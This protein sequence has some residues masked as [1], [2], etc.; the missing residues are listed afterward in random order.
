M[1]RFVRT[2][3]N[4]LKN[5]IL[6]MNGISENQLDIKAFAPDLSQEPFLMFKE[7]GKPFGTF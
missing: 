1:Y 3:A 4:D 7:R 2:K 6:K 5:A